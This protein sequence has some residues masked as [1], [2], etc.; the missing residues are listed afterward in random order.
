MGRQCSRAPDHSTIES[1]YS[2]ILPSIVGG[3]DV[4]SEITAVQIS[5]RA[6][7]GEAPS[8]HGFSHHR[9]SV[10]SG[11]FCRGSGFFFLIGWGKRALLFRNLEQGGIELHECGV[12]G[13]VL[14]VTGIAHGLFWNRPGR[15]SFVKRE[16]SPSA[17]EARVF[18]V[19]GSRH[20][21]V[22]LEVSGLVDRAF[23]G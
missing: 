4:Q 17:R 18:D 5:A 1:K 8:P 16:E 22:G 10:L 15:L 12:D 19:S 14:L 2:R 23:A 13:G 9:G 6:E 11:G 21:V 3:V 7:R 20:D